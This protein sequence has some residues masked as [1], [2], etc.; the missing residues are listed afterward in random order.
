MFLASKVRGSKS[1][2]VAF[3]FPGSQRVA[4]SSAGVTYDGGIVASGEA[5][6]AVGHRTN[7][8][9][10][11]DVGGADGQSVVVSRAGDPAGDLA[12]QWV[13]ILEK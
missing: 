8:G 9:V 5:D 12:L 1:T 6:G 11:R 4:V 13:N 7:E 10:V 3:W 2:E